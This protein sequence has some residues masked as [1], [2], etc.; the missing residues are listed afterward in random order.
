[1]NAMAQQPTRYWIQPLLSP[2]RNLHLKALVG[3][4]PVYLLYLVSFRAPLRPAR[5]DRVYQGFE[6]W[7]V[8]QTLTFA[9][10]HGIEF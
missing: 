4:L 8:I 10:T 7:I 3:V 6:P 9:P 1:M 2:L 5:S